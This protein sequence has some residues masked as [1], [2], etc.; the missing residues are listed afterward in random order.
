MNNTNDVSTQGGVNI[1]GGNVT[2]GNIVGRDFNIAIHLQDV[3][4]AASAARTIAM[5]LSK[6]DLESETIRA[7]L[8]GLIEEL[9]KTHSTLVKAISPLRRVQ[10]DPKTFENQFEVVYND[11]RDFYDAYDFWEERTHCHKVRQI[12]HRLEKHQVA[13][14]QTPQWNQLRGYLNALSNA[15]LDV[16][17]YHYRPFMERFNQVMV[18]IDAH[19]TKRELAQAIMLKQAFLTELTPQYDAIREVLRLMTETIGEIEVALA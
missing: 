18:E 12:Q 11:F 9:R 6:G 15:D 8:L 1:D 7:E 2:A 3:N 10:N 4:D 13:I 14:T 19:I 17:E 16:I 5:T